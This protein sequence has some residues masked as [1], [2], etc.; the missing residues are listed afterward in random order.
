M[1]KINVI[2]LFHIYITQP[3]EAGDTL[4]GG[5]HVAHLRRL[6]L[7]ANKENGYVVTDKGQYVLDRII[8]EI[9]RQ[10]VYIETITKVQIGLA[11]TG[12]IRV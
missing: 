8:I 9:N 7:I 12:D 4:S 3:C 2:E 6:G 5:E 10:G 11:D 1:K